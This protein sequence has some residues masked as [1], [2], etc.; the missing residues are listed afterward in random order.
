MNRRSSHGLMALGALIIALATIAGAVASHALTTSLDSSSL[1]SFETAVRFQFF[2]GL[3]LMALALYRERRPRSR[4]LA[5]AAAG[6]VLGIL[7]FCGG[8]YTSSLGGPAWIA[9]LAPAGGI[10]L[11][12]SWL[13]V[14][15]DAML[16]ATTGATRPD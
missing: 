6:L 8:V 14:A 11:I 10:A 1:H 16:G 7:L 5:A 4:L 3:G 12:L 13:A 9:A 15:I 2:H